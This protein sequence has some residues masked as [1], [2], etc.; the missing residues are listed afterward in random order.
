[1]AVQ[2]IPSLIPAFGAPDYRDW[3]R[4]PAMESNEEKD[5]IFR[6]EIIPYLNNYAEGASNFDDALLE[7]E[8]DPNAATITLADFVKHLAGTIITVAWQENMRAFVQRAQDPE[9]RLND[10]WMTEVLEG[11][12]L[13]LPKLTK[14][15][16]WWVLC[17]RLRLFSL[18]VGCTSAPQDPLGCVSAV[19]A[20]V[21]SR[22]SAAGSASLRETRVQTQRKRQHEDYQVAWI[23]PLEVEQIAAL[24]M[25]DEQHEPLS[26]PR[27]DYNVYTLGS[28]GSHNVVIAGLPQTGNNS[29]AAVITQA[30]TTFPNLRF[31]LLVG[32]GGGVPTTTDNGMIR[33]GD[34]VVSKPTGEHSGVLQY[35][36]GKAEVARFIRTGA[37]APPPTI[38]LS[39]A[40]A[41]AAQRARSRKDS[42]LD[43]IE[44]ID[45]NIRGLRR[46]MRPGSAL[47]HLY[48][49]EYTHLDPKL[50]CTQCGCDPSQRVQLIDNE[51][52]DHFVVIHRGIIASG[53]LVIKDGKLRDDLAKQ[54]NI[55]C[56]ETEAAGVLVNFPCLVI[57][58]ISDYCDSHKNDYWHGYA[59][60]AAAA[61]A[62]ELIFYIPNDVST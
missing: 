29:A 33:L 49:A 51:D 22:I 48:R 10:H 19:R 27:T 32:I 57:R 1:M 16:L 2:G 61:Y 35:D 59:A 20:H 38:L 50:P 14:D 7:L 62:R 15:P 24:E 5:V 26:Q 45:T 58:G 47:D 39:A 43:N 23:C 13:A 55:L 21:S 3:L 6:R 25:L 40:Q 44:R 11:F 37:L 31:C 54:Y 8:R 42:I 53:E 34:V 60:A 9:S 30:R 12:E 52:D 46:Y 36:H 56:F 17:G 28:I 18:Q 41:L 4:L